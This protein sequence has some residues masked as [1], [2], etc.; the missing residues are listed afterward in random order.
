LKG[1]YVKMV[2][3]GIEYADLQLIAEVYDAMK[4]MLQMNNEEIADTFEK[5]NE[6]E[7]SSYLLKITST[8]LRKKDAESGG[9]I[10]DHIRGT[11]GMKGTG[12]VSVKYAGEA[13][14]FHTLSQVF[15]PPSISGQ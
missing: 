7:L 12:R 1:N 9:Y 13:C 6:G 3:N 5:W 4:T 14:L 8:I 11:A 2:H 10:L 15:T